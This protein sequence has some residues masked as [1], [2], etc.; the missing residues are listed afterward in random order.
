[1][2][3]IDLPQVQQPVELAGAAYCANPCVET[4]DA[5]YSAIYGARRKGS[6]S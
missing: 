3:L 6:S 2:K 1:M 5:F 4:A